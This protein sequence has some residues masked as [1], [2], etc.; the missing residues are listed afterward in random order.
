MIPKDLIHIPQRLDLR[1]QRVHPPDHTLLI[2][3]TPLRGIARWR[4][5]RQPDTLVRPRVV[6]R[7]DLIQRARGI[8]AVDVGGDDTDLVHA[9]VARGPEAREPVAG[10][11]GR[12]RGHQLGSG[13]G[14]VVEEGR[15][16]GLHR[17]AGV[18]GGGEGRES[19]P[20]V[21]GFVEEPHVP[22]RGG[23][24]QGGF[25]VVDF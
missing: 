18:L 25:G 8:L 20:G 14:G 4:Q 17:G 2:E 24:R 22:W 16:E 23:A 3:R 1:D 5:L 11:D 6:Q 7:R 10:R 15:H 19:V 21:V 13:G 9:A 12:G